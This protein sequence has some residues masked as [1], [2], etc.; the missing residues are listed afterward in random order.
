MGGNQHI[1]FP[2]TM[3][4]AALADSLK[5]M[6]DE[7]DA[8]KDVD[9]VVR[10]TIGANQGA[11]FSG[12]GY[13]DDLYKH[14]EKWGLTHLKSSPEAYETLTSEKNVA[15]FESL[16]IFNRRETEARRS[17][18]QDAYATEV[19]IE[20]RAL[21]RILSTMVAPAALED[22]DAVDGAGFASALLDRKKELVALLL[23]RTDALSDAIAAW[24]EDDLSAAASYAHE[25]VKPAMQAA[26][27]AADGLETLVD[28]RLWPLPDYA[29]LIYHQ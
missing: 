6:C 7:A 29:E 20:A 26:R 13:S 12:D 16:G 14:A 11:L 9:Q 10:E 17:V 8:G 2:L 27:D 18:L 28:A 24:P 15:L 25:A 5:A 3:V 21:L 22:V 19:G 1:A 23:E 4:N